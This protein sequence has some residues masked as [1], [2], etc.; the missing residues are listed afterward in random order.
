MKSEVRRAFDADP[1]LS[2]AQVSVEAEGGKLVL[3]GVVSSEADRLH[4]LAVA[5]SAASPREIVDKITLKLGLRA[6][7]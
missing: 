7:K 5:S 4:A 2:T 6:Q 3:R 1:D